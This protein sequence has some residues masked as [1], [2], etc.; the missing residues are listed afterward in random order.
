MISSEFGGTGG[1]PLEPGVV[2]EEPDIEIGAG[3]SSKAISRRGGHNAGP[4]RG[5]NFGNQQQQHNKHKGGYERHHPYA[6]HDRKEHKQHNNHRHEQQS[7]TYT[8]PPPP[9][10]TFGGGIPGLF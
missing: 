1:K 3:P 9:V 7:S 5:G 2:V 6:K 8:G 10:P 4:Q